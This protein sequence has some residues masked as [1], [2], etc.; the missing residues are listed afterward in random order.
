[1][2]VERWDTGEPAELL[3]LR[4]PWAAGVDGEDRRHTAD[5]LIE[6]FRDWQ[7][8][9]EGT[10]QGRDGLYHAEISPEAHYVTVAAKNWAILAGKKG[11]VVR[12]R[13]GCRQ[14]G[15]G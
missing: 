9:V 14:T 4:S 13:H 7:T 1:M 12:L 8:L 3:E 6:A 5:Q 10:K 15:W 11:P 2:R